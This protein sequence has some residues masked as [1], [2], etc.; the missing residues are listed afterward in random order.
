MSGGDLDGALTFSWPDEEGKHEEAPEDREASAA[1]P[2][3]RPEVRSVRTGA[4]HVCTVADAA[5]RAGRTGA[6]YLPQDIL[7]AA[8][9]VR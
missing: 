1:L 5:V 2:G 8:E 3:R 4:R 6:T 9:P 7:R